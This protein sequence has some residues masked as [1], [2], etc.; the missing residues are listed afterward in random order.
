MTNQSAATFL[1]KIDWLVHLLTS[2]FNLAIN[3][4]NVKYSSS[5]KFQYL[6]ALGDKVIWFLF[7]QNFSH[8]SPACVSAF[9]PLGLL[10]VE[11]SGWIQELPVIDDRCRREAKWKIKRQKAK[12]HLL[13]MSA[14]FV[15]TLWFVINIIRQLERNVEC[16]QTFPQKKRFQ[17]IVPWNTQCLTMKVRPV[18]NV[19]GTSIFQY[20][21]AVLNV[22]LRFK[23]KLP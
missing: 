12:P 13:W 23:H 6:L 9:R 5:W 20:F 1:V 21:S 8:F 16:I 3:R 18:S 19:F 7:I 10:Q 15:L 22:H 17:S 4:R 14:A 11:L 2:R